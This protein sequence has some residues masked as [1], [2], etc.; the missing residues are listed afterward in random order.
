MSYK[1]VDRFPSDVDGPRATQAYGQHTGMPPGQCMDPQAW[2]WWTEHTKWE[3]GA[4]SGGRK[5][6]QRPK[7]TPTVRPPW[8]T[9]PRPESL[10]GVRTPGR[11]PSTAGPP[12]TGMSYQSG[13]Q[14][15]R[16]AA[17]PSAAPPSA[18]P[19]SRE[20]EEARAEIQ[21]LTELKAA[22]DEIEL[23]RAH[24][25]QQGALNTSTPLP[26]PAPAEPE[27][28]AAVVRTQPRV[29]Y[30]LMKTPVPPRAKAIENGSPRRLGPLDRAKL[31]N[32]R[33]AEQAAMRRAVGA[34]R[35]ARETQLKREQ[36]NVRKK[37]LLNVTMTVA[38]SPR[39][40][41][42]EPWRNRVTK[43][44]SQ[45]V[46]RKDEEDAP[47]YTVSTSLTNMPAPPIPTPVPSFAPDAVATR[48]AA[49]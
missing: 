15:A 16:Y 25:Q 9:L 41:K 5:Q 19:L 4:E 27:P 14:S 37:K 12:G 20:L 22:R 6:W 24:L 48:E 47:F 7:M 21:R 33:A 18:A 36:D 26:P 2:A 49:K 43:P 28:P 45:G 38:N 32:G 42:Y 17:P 29:T 1:T 40:N 10:R 11:T 3:A 46:E 34:E 35:L 31:Q 30:R 39:Y 44:F 23:L 13:S 8:G